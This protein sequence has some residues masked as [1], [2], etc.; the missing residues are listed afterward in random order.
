MPVSAR[1][2]YQGVFKTNLKRKHLTSVA[3]FGQME[4]GLSQ[5][6]KDNMPASLWRKFFGAVQQNN[7]PKEFSREGLKSKKC[8]SDGHSYCRRPFTF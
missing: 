8:F 6:R 4:L 7:I 2:C 3:S 5:L 1:R